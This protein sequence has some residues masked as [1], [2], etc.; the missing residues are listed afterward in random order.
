[1]PAEDDRGLKERKSHACFLV[2]TDDDLT[3][4]EAEACTRTRDRPRNDI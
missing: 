4:I 3:Q 2:N 1:M